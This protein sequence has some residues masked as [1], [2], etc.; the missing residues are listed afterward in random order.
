MLEIFENDKRTK[1]F[2]GGV[3]SPEVF[4]K[5][6]IEA[7]HPTEELRPIG[8]VALKGAEHESTEIQDAYSAGGEL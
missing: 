8:E 2:V 4:H 1:M 5:E 3:I 7:G 6:A